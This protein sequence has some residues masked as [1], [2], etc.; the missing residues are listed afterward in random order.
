MSLSQAT[1]NNNG[2]KIDPG[3]GGV[4]ILD[5]VHD[6]S[7]ALERDHLE[8]NYEDVADVVERDSILVRIEAARHA[9]AK[10]A[11]VVFVGQVA[12]L[13]HAVTPA[14]HEVAPV[15]E[16]IKELVH[17]GVGRRLQWGVVAR[18]EAAV[19]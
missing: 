1:Y 18:G 6:W 3:S 14:A 17:G 15:L 9:L 11:C 10:V 7:P 12:A 8:H 13:L 5:Q 2:H 4:R 19:S 16:N